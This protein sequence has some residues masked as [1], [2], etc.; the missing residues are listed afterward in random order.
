MDE[1]IKIWNELGFDKDIELKYSSPTK[2]VS[3]MSEFNNKTADFDWKI[4]R[5]DT[6][7]YAQ[8]PD[9]FMSGYYTSRPQVKKNIRDLTQSFHSSLRMTSQQAIR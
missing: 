2:Y 6:F 3:Q 8:N 1:L 9:L 4:R 5:D 7:P